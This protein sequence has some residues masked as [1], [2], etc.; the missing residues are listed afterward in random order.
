MYCLIGNDVFN[1]LE[2]FD[3]NTTPSIINLFTRFAANNSCTKCIESRFKLPYYDI[4]T[5]YHIQND[6]VM[7]YNIYKEHKEQIDN[8]LVSISKTEDS[9]NWLYNRNKD[10]VIDSHDIVF[11]KYKY[12]A[13]CNNY[14]VC[15]FVKN[16]YEIMVAPLLTI[17]SPLLYFVIPYL[18]VRFK[19]GIKIPIRSFIQVLLTIMKK[20]HLS[21]VHLLSFVVSCI[22]YIHNMLK[23]FQ[24]SKNTYA[25]CKSIITKLNNIYE[26]LTSSLHFM[27]YFKHESKHISDLISTKNSNF[28]TK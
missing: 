6:I 12:F 27:T 3:S 26:Y 9:I 24:S 1:D 25:V 15:L 20:S 13:L 5:L 8:L 2:I 4:D 18:V 19:I 11:F 16:L 28:S 17:V 23:T 10:D 14:S 7:E 21:S 22:I